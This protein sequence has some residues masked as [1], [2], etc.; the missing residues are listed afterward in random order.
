MCGRYA[1]HV[2]VTSEWL[3]ILK[4][5]PA[6]ISTGF[7]IAPTQTIPAI[8]EDGTFPMRW[9]LVPAWSKEASPRYATF[10][11]RLE[12]ASEKPTFRN[13][14][15][16]A[17]TCLIPALGYYEWRTEQGVKQPYFVQAPAQMGLLV[18][19]GL[20]ELREGAY[21]CTILTR[22]SAG[23]LAQLHSRMPVMLAPDDARSWLTE[24]CRAADRLW[25][26]S[27]HQD[28]QYHAV[29][30]AVGNTH[31]QGEVLI[32]PIRK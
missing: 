4:D 14:W 5:W 20:W 8:R 17:Q 26:S 3:D 16:H 7:N 28:L 21:S 32:Q 23:D 24:G 27:I 25:E 31:N 13:A 12:S 29:G 9:G 15:H 18:F 19:A 1:N 10:N 6:G 2:D 30:R 11:A 22:E